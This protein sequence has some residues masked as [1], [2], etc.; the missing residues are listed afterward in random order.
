MGLYATM[1]LDMS[2]PADLK[3]E[4]STDQPSH[5]SSDLLSNH[6]PKSSADNLSPVSVVVTVLNEAET[7]ADLLVALEKQTITPQAVIIT[8]GGS[9][10]NTVKT[11]QTWQETKR[12]PITVMEI[13]GN[14]SVGRN[15]AIAET[16]TELIAITDAGCMPKKDWLEELLKT[17]QLSGAEVVAGYYEG[18]PQTALQTAM[19]PYALVMP[20]K[21]NPDDFLPATR[22]MLL[23]K[24]A[25][26]ASGQ[27][28]ESLSDNE[29]YAF[30]HQLKKV[31]KIAFAES[32]IVK[33]RPPAD[34]SAFVMMIFRFARGD[35]QAGLWRP[36]VILIFVRYAVVFVLLLFY[37][38]V[39][40]YAI[41][42][43]ML[44]LFSIYIIWAIMKNF[45]YAKNSW[46]WLPVL[47]IVS[48][49]TVM[50]GTMVG[51]GEK[52]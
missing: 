1:M 42:A 19:V 21:V 35:A 12:L 46:Y 41:L 25:F 17:Q 29:D 27:F 3:N 50:A 51:V 30:A 40:S 7:I 23:T 43:A 20:D 8:D 36:K 24:R 38:L 26:L 4:F 22:S 47:Q 13:K 52:R 15:A 18:K 44:V 45:K 28:D 6:S 32:A 34:L 39:Y 2:Q 10:D 16:K 48:D 33:W 37:C 14:R 5:S 49:L 31:A 11:I 9:T